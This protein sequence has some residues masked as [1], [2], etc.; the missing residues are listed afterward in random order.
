VRGGGSGGFDPDLHAD[1]SQA[2][3]PETSNLSLPKIKGREAEA[4]RPSSVPGDPKGL[5]E[6]VL[7]PSEVPAS[8][9]VAQPGLTPCCAPSL[10]GSVLP[11]VLSADDLRGHWVPRF[12]HGLGFS[13]GP[14]RPVVVS[15][16]PHLPMRLHPPSSFPPPAESCG[17]RAALRTW[18]NL[19]TQPNSRRAPPLGS[20]SLIAA[21]AT[22]VHHSAGNPDPAVRSALDVSHVL[23]G[24]LRPSPSR[25]CS[26]PLPRPGFALQGF[27]PRRGAVPGFPGRFMPSWCWAHPPATSEC[28]PTFRALLPAS[29]A[30]PP[31][32][33]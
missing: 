5:P 24:F 30:V 28:A 23:D 7:S 10:E 21:P 19:A 18:L 13:P 12:R 27:V 33:D 31:G 1:L 25:A 9:A 16:P 17:L 14:T 4:P 11:G 2:P 3:K 20:S 26:I 15:R 29:S 32:T 6:Y 8:P 22:G